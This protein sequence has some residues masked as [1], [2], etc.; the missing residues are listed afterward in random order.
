MTE[1]HLSKEE[2]IKKFKSEVDQADWEMLSPHFQRGALFKIDSKA[3][4]FRIAADLALDN[5]SE[6]RNYISENILI[7][8]S[9]KDLELFGKDKNVFFANFLVVQPYVLFQVY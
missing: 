3:D 9:D 6:V 1:I 2:L 7:K 4:M 5:V 8:A